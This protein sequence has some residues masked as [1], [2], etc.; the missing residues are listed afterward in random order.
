MS[1]TEQLSC[2]IPDDYRGWRLDAALADLFPAYSRSV[3]QQWIQSGFVVVDGQRLK[4]R[5]KLL[6]GEQVDIEAV[7]EAV[8]DCQPQAMAFEIVYQDDDLIVIN[9]PINLVMHPAAGNPDG[10]VQNGLLHLDPSLANIPRAGIVHRLDKDTSGLFVVA[11]SL[12]AHTSLVAQL[13][14]R[15]MHREYRA[16]VHG[17]LVAGGLPAIV[18]FKMAFI[19]LAALLP[20]GLIRGQL[21][22]ML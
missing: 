21:R 12:A 14:S 3:L 9:K 5:S 2:R 11:R 19:G 18:L 6:G 13:Q 4:P 7:R 1:T 20:I 17:Q 8:V 15:S 22:Q 16:V 10:T